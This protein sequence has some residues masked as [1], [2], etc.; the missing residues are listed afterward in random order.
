MTSAAIAHYN[1]NIFSL[2]T[3]FIL[4]HCDSICC[5]RFLI[6]LIL[7]P[8]SGNSNSTTFRWWH[9][10]LE[11]SVS[12]TNHLVSVWLTR[13]CYTTPHL[14]LVLL[15]TLGCLQVLED[16]RYGME[17]NR[18]EHMQTR[19]TTVKFLGELY[20]MRLVDSQVIAAPENPVFRPESWF[21][22]CFVLRAGL[23]SVVS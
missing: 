10:L 1:S 18:W 14:L 7:V 6:V 12:S 3:S 19:I 17:I 13:C 11:S 2:S 9:K 4:I 22:E 8:F 5:T 20:V 23:S 15:D 16:V 21:V